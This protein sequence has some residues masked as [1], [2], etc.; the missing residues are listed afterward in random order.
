M[1][2]RAKAGHKAAKAPRRK[3]KN[4]PAATPGGDRRLSDATLQEQL[5]QSR[6]ELKEALE[7]QTATREVLDLIS[8]TPTDVQPIFSAIAESAAR[9]CNA[10]FGVV[11]RYDGELLHYAASHNFT[12]QVLNDISK[13]YPKKPD[14]STAA[15]RAILDGRIAHV[16]N[17][18]G[19]REYAH[20]L[21]LAGNWR[22]TL[23]VPMLH[24]GKAVGAIGIGKAETGLFSEQQIQL[25]TTFAAQAVIAIENTRLL[26]E[27]RESLQRQTATA[28]V[29][30]V[31]SSSPGDLRP[32]FDAMLENAVRICEAAFGSMLQHE[33]DGFRRVALHNAPMDYEKYS[34]TEPFL[35]PTK[36]LSHIL[37]TMQAAQVPDMAVAEPQ[38][39]ITRLGGA[40]TLLNVPMIKENELIGIITVFRQ[41][42]RPFSDKQI[43][44][45]KNFAARAVIAI[46]NTRLLSE[47]RERTEQIA[48]LN[49]L[50]EQRVSDQVDEIE[51]MSRLRRFL[52]PQVADLIVASGTEKQL[53]SHR[54][55]ITA[56]FC[57]LRGFTGFSESSDPEDVMALLRDYHAAIGQIIIKYSGTLERYAGDGV[58]VV[59]NDPVP[60]ENPAL[61]AVQMAL[62]MREAIGALT[63]AWRRWGHDIGFG[64]GI[65]HG[66]ATL[67]T[68]GF[69]G[70]FDYA[71]IGT[72]SNVASRLC[73]EAKPGQILIS[74]RVLTKVEN[75][76]E[77]E[78]VGEFEL[79][80]IRRPLAAYNV[81]AASEANGD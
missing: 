34:K 43:E 45:V 57:D 80:G 73:D 71:A 1:K 18:L 52:P 65:A 9:L 3:I 44:L 79:K 37:E 4:C 41:E 61:Q 14:R 63:E 11:W 8:R 24:E 66:F 78:L 62:E 10:L 74:A 59:F 28:D 12:P 72:V 77:V 21:A 53:E 51:R 6:H 29:L 25:L 75:A 13:T 20:E 22:A 7:H 2:R 76:V 67:G 47:L 81:L 69:E 42:V 30:K 56:L 27:L 40:R 16:P 55:E 31:I 48:K 49:Q 15:G 68:I 17:M 5:D 60:V 36:T 64:I 32:V 50:L 23:S 19:D 70:R 58:M 38:S 33:G 26:N 46:E 39:P 54:R 35:R